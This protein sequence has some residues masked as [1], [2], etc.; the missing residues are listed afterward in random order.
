MRFLRGMVVG[1]VVS[2]ALIAVDRADASE[3]DEAWSIATAHYGV[4][5]GGP[6]AISWNH[7]GSSV[8][9]RSTWMTA[10]TRDPSNYTEC[11]ITFNYD[12]AWDWPKLCT[13]MEHEVGHLTGHV[14]EEDAIM[15]T[16]Y[17]GPSPECA[18]R[19]KIHRRRLTFVWY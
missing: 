9:A 8:N 3:Q 18:P 14:H 7:A 19:R 4:P 13:V 2:L 15:S 6:V 12:V 1:A 17:N 5:C 16:Y 10:D 11:A